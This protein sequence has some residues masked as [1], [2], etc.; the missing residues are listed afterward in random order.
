VSRRPDVGALRTVLRA[1]G[2]ALLPTDTVYGLAAALDA[3]DGVEALYALKGR[4]RSEPFQ[5]LLYA[6]ALLEEALR[7]LDPGTRRAAEAL[8][9][10]PA[11]CLVADPRGRYGAAAGDGAGSVG[12]RAP[13]VSGPLLELDL[14]LVATSANDPGGADPAELARVPARLRAGAACVVDAG[15]LPGVAS[16][17]VDLRG[18]AAGGGALLR[19]PGADPAAI[20]A[21]LERAGI[22]LASDWVAS[23]G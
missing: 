14:P 6:P 21:A 18:V 20:G 3:P 4:P 15:A 12:L 9:P 13:R 7:A 19:R 11:T 5:V 10:G 23:A 17:V 16:A 22:P 2:L 8:L 1:G